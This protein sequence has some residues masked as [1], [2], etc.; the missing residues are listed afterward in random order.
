MQ[1]KEQGAQRRPGRCMAY[2]RFLGRAFQT[3]LKAVVEY[4][5]NF[6]LQFFG[7][8]LN[9]ATFA[10]FWAVLISRAGAIGGYGFVDVMFV[11]GFVSSAFGLAH[12]VFGNIHSFSRLVLEGSLDVYLLQPKD[13]W[14]NLLASRT[15][16]SAWG[17]FAYG[18]IVLS[19]LPGVGMERLAIFM[20]MLVPAAMIFVA[21]FAAAE[22]LCFFMGQT[23]AVS[24]AI[25]E[26][27]LSF[28]LYPEGIHSQAFRWV[29]YSILPSGF[30]AFVPLRIFNQVSWALV[31]PLWA[32]AIAY[33]GLS[34]GLFR[35]GLKRYESGNRMDARI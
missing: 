32:V 12:I 29:L 3:N 13:V 23:T 15:V 2:L 31:P 5:M 8:M 11:W 4:R 9:N 22:S 28:S 24:G 35:L 14:L 1:E 25:S 17:D 21:I 27:L 33:L 26:F 16:V 7:M 18:F 30:I 10:A 19:F 20:A 34:Y 6:F